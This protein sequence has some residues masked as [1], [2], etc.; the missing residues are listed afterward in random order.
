MQPYCC[1]VREAGGRELHAHT[2]RQHAGSYCMQSCCW[3]KEEKQGCLCM[4]SVLASFGWV[5][6]CVCGGGGGGV[7]GCGRGWVGNNGGGGGG[8]MDS[9]VKGDTLM[10][11]C[12][13]GMG[14][15]SESAHGRMYVRVRMQNGVGQRERSWTRASWYAH[16]EWGWD[17]RAFMDA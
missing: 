6:M 11:V 4:W 9:L 8:K 5:G 12:A 15:G 13:C 10:L 17:A 16:G 2:Q 14:L 7:R 3:G 1:K